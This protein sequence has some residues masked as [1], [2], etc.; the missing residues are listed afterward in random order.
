MAMAVL[1]TPGIVLGNASSVMPIPLTTALAMDA[2][3]VDS[4]GPLGDNWRLIALA[5][6]CAVAVTLRRTTT[7][8]KPPSEQT[9][10]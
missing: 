3:T 10:N 9:D 6:V 8:A 4:Q 5:V 7:P 1:A 2:A